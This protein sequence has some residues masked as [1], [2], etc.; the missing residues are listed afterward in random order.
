MKPGLMLAQQKTILLALH[1]FWK[2]CTEQER[3]RVFALFSVKQ[4]TLLSTD[5][6]PQIH[7]SIL[8]SANL[9]TWICGFVICEPNLF[10]MLE[11]SPSPQIHTFLNLY[12][13]KNHLERLF[14]EGVVQY[15]AVIYGFVNCR[16]ALCG[17]A[18]LRNFRISDSGMSLIVCGFADLIKC[19]ALGYVQKVLNKPNS[20]LLQVKILP[21]GSKVPVRNCT[22]CW[23]LALHGQT[24]NSEQENTVF[25][26]SKI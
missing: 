22:I 13:T 1:P 5:G 12:K 7:K 25:I 17:M 14:W 20:A 10:C 6:S 3:R 26:F 2:H 11:T 9:Q 24:P 19:S 21:K 4:S 23:N 16:F 8:T 18:H 15:V